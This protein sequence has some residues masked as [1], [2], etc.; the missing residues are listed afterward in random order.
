MGTEE[1]MIL[2][3]GGVAAGMVAAGVARKA[4]SEAQ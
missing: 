2:V 3:I 4:L 1:G